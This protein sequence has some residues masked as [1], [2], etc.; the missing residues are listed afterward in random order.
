[1]PDTKFLIGEKVYLRPIEPADLPHVCR[2][3]N[4]PETRRQI[5]EIEPKST[6]DAVEW[7][8]KVYKDSNRVWFVVVLRENDRVI[9]EAGLLR[10]FH[11]WRTA[12]ATMV[13]G[14]K[15]ATG[16]GCGTE[17]MRLLLDY[18]FNTLN[19]HRVALG[20]F[21]FN[22]RALRFYEKCGFR[23]EGALRDGY[24]CDGAYHNVVLMSILDAEFGKD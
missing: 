5:G 18:A 9:G 13:I 17:A 21:D 3:V 16:K 12:D 11:P 1:M 15:D 20:V 19:L 22:E 6:A 8:Q 10:I 4:D 24:Y 2:W 7:L 14:E 23:R